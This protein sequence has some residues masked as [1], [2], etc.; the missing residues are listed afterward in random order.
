MKRRNLAGVFIAAVVAVIA[1]CPPGAADPTV[2]QLQPSLPSTPTRDEQFLAD[3]ARAGLRVA[4]V[5]TAVF[6]AHDTCAYLAAGHDGLEAAE[7]GMRNNP[8]MTRADE[9]AAY[10]AAVAAY[11]PSRLR[12][13]GTV[14]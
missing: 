14:A 11:C 3:L 2:Q 6:G 9:I 5:R 1:L 13:S 8:T 7:Q 4:D 12:I 10:N